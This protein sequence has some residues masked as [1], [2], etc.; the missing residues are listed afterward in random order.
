MGIPST[1]TPEIE[2]PEDM[3]KLQFANY[4]RQRAA[5]MAEVETDLDQ[6]L[7]IAPDVFITVANAI[8]PVMN[9]DQVNEGSAKPMMKT[10]DTLRTELG[11]VF[12]GTPFLCAVAGENCN[13]KKGD[14]IYLSPDQNVIKVF[15]YKNIRYLAYNKFAALGHIN[16][17]HKDLLEHFDVDYTS[18]EV[19]NQTAKK[20]IG[21][22]SIDTPKA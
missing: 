19:V 17:E 8:D 1:K 7:N 2:A 16:A 14:F 9:R 6:V 3:A 22:D 4:E 12:A 13:F 11:Q 10:E 21:I 18:G 20:E 15:T 5:F